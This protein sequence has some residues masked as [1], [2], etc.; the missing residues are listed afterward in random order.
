MPFHEMFDAREVEFYQCNSCGTANVEYGFETVDPTV[1]VRVPVLGLT[2][3]Q[4]ALNCRSEPRVVQDYTCENLDCSGG[5]HGTGR[6]TRRSSKRKQVTL[7][8]TAQTTEVLVGCP[9]VLVLALGRFDED[10]GKLFDNISI[11]AIHAVT[12]LSD[13][14]GGIEGDNVLYDT[15]YLTLTHGPFY[16]SCIPRNDVIGRCRS[17]VTMASALTKVTTPRSCAMATA[18]ST[19]TTPT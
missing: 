9:D 1:V 10:G 19:A 15:V 3:L 18:G 4:D 11:D 16:E 2:S 7:K 5:S 13:L 17:C 8:T 14:H 6:R 12:D